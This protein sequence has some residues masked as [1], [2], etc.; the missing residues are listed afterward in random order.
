MGC[1]TSDRSYPNWRESPPLPK[2]FF[3]PLGR[4][5]YLLNTE[6]GESNQFFYWLSREESTKP[7]EQPAYIPSPEEIRHACDLVLLDRCTRIS[8]HQRKNKAAWEPSARLSGQAVPVQTFKKPRNRE[9]TYEGL[10][11]THQDQPV[12]WEQITNTQL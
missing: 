2:P 12:W 1:I 3:S 6:A 11:H 5:M 8:M 10:S 9:Y 7:Q 4:L